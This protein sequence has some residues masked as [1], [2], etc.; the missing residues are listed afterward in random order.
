MKFGWAKAAA[1][2]M[3]VLVSV[4]VAAADLTPVK[5]GVLKFGTVNWELKALKNA[6]FDHANGIDL[7]IVPFA[8]GDATKIALQGGAVD[9]I[10]SDV[11]SL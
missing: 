9:I 2:S 7:D 1:V 11:C 4:N 8:G 6:G 10:V 3:S 5:V